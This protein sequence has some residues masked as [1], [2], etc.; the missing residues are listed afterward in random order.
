MFT[1]GEPCAHKR[2]PIV[3]GDLSSG[4][5]HSGCLSTLKAEEKITEA[6]RSGAGF[7]W[8]EHDKGLFEGTEKFF[9]S[10][11]VGNLVSS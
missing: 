10:N 2:T 5:V 4:R 11:Y 8:H 9:R 1:G 3:P 6:F 7:G